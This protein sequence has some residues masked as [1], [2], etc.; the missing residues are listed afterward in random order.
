MEKHVRRS[1][2]KED[3]EVDYVPSETIRESHKRLADNGNLEKDNNNHYKRM[4]HEQTYQQSL[5]TKENDNNCETKVCKDSVNNTSG[6]EDVELDIIPSETI[7]ESLKSNLSDNKKKKTQQS[8]D[9]HNSLQSKETEEDGVNSEMKTTLDNS[10]KDKPTEAASDEVLMENISCTECDFECE[11]KEAAEAHMVFRQSDTYLRFE[12][13]RHIELYCHVCCLCLPERVSFDIHMALHKICVA[14]KC[15]FASKST[16][17]LGNHTKEFHSKVSGEIESNVKC[18]ACKT[19]YDTQLELEWHIETEHEV[20]MMAIY[21]CLKCAFVGKSVEELELHILTKHAF[22]CDLC[23]EVFSCIA[24]LKEHTE[25]SHIKEIENGV[26]SKVDHPP[27]SSTPV[28]CYNC[29]KCDQ[30]FKD[31]NSFRNHI[32]SHHREIST[33]SCDQC[34]F[35]TNSVKEYVSHIIEVHRRTCIYKCCFCDFECADKTTLEQH[36]IEFHE[37]FAVLTGLARNQ[38]YVSESFDNF[39]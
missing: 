36:T 27:R 38:V 11:S 22:L 28:Q 24:K 13:E 2:G 16:E 31:D 10:V 7:S 25:R 9:E 12:K 14:K 26:P 15:N 35:E 5:E 23:K 30:S 19:Q 1:H 4:K 18:A 21:N 39:K 37:M 34:E 20:Q 17:N 32:S 29:E 8:Q 3:V 33:Q 6:K